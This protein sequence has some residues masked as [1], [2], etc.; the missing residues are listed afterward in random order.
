MDRRWRGP[1]CW[2]FLGLPRVK[3]TLE[4]EI[5]IESNRIDEISHVLKRKQS[6][7][8]VTSLRDNSRRERGAPAQFFFFRSSFF[9]H[10]RKVLSTFAHTHVR[11]YHHLRHEMKGTFNL[12]TNIENLYL[13]KQSESSFFAM[14][15]YCRHRINIEITYRKNS[16]QI[17]FQMS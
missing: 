2:P 17:R 8:R 5:S 13:S 9:S 11:R 10:T 1:S 4:S 7:T 16:A 15:D 6:A 14:H 3:E 12:K